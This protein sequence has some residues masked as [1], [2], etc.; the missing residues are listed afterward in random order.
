MALTRLILV[1]VCVV[2]LSVILAPLQFAII[3]LLPSHSGKIPVFWHR[4]FLRLIGVRVY[5]HGQPSRDLPVMIVANHIS[6]SDILILG[7]IGEFCFIAKHEVDTLPLIN[8]LSRLQRTVF[9]NRERSRDAGVQA[10]TIAK[11]LV[12][13]DVMVLFAEGTTGNGNKLLP[14]KSSLFGAPKLALERGDLDVVHIQ[15][16]AIAYNNLHGMPLG[17]YHQS[18]AAWPGDIPLGPHLLNFI[19]QGAFDVDVRFGEAIAMT[20]S[21]NRKN[22]AS[23]AYQAIRKDF[24]E[25]RRMAHQS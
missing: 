8:F 25:L 9:V 2:L 18:H 12:S 4:L 19:R 14:F 3:K 23:S 15:P 1:L 13:G 7:S 20:P 10:D 16:C 17:R 24:A 21:S 5:L 22:V 11:R 6:W